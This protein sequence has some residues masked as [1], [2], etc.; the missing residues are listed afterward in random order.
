MEFT[1][2]GDEA[3]AQA[4]TGAIRYDITYSPAS[5]RW[6]VDASWKTAPGPEPALGE[7]RR[8]PVVAVDVNVGH[9]AVAVVR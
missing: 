4:A 2:R 8:H 7:L 5:G 1:Y 3:A 6:H 9:L